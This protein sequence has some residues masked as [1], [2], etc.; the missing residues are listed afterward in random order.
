MVKEREESAKLDTERE[1]VKEEL[2]RLRS[3]KTETGDLGAMGVVSSS[4]QGSRQGSSSNNNKQVGG[5]VVL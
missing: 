4:L 5:V 3:G 2:Q 1:R